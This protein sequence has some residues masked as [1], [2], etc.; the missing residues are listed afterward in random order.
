VVFDLIDLRIPIRGHLQI[1]EKCHEGDQIEQKNWRSVA[2]NFSEVNAAK[3]L[4]C[5]LEVDG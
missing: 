1:G 3:D 4:E 5:V 2:V